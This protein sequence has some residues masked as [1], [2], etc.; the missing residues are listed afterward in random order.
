MSSN[1]SEVWSGELMATMVVCFIKAGYG[2][3]HEKDKSHRHFIRVRNKDFEEVFSSYSFDA[4]K[5]GT[6]ENEE[7][8]GHYNAAQHY[9]SYWLG[10]FPDYP[11]LLVVK[12]NE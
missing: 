10:L 3:Q 1:K 4:R 9:V 8:A 6:S 5:N 11:N 7:M 12:P 2:V